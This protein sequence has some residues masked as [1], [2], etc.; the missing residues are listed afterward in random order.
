MGVDKA[1]KT[2]G[3][4][5]GGQHGYA[6]S[7]GMKFS[8][9]ARQA[10]EKLGLVIQGTLVVADNGWHAHALAQL[11]VRFLQLLPGRAAL[12]EVLSLRT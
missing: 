9:K 7:I 4:S 5:R 8:G 3:W 12:L 1:E 6:A 2:K 10:M 11:P